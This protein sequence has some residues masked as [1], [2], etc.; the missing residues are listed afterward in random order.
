[1]NCVTIVIPTYNEAENIEKII[2]GISNAL[3]HTKYGKSY[4]ICVVDDNS[5]DNTGEIAEKLAKKYPVD[6]IHRTGKRGYGEAC[7]EGF[8]H[9][10][11]HSDVIITMDCDLSHDPRVIPFFIKKIEQGCD[12]VIGSRYIAG[13]KIQNWSVLR[14][15]ISKSANFFTKMILGLPVSDCTSGYRAYK[16]EV[17][18]KI[19]VEKIFADGYSFLEEL[20]YASYRAGY[21]IAEIPICFVE[22][23]YGASKLSKKEMLKFIMTIVRLKR[24]KYAK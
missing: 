10:V 17:L 8:K 2:I 1:M 6:V 9:A 3:D 14:R 23:Q 15:I 11:V 19:G 4:M 7:K 22:R 18:K 24:G 12:V 5:P 16:T 20:L 13:G 21:V